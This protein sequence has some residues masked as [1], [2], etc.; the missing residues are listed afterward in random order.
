MD[1]AQAAIKREADTTQSAEL[2][3]SPRGRASRAPPWSYKLG[4]AEETEEV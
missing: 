1:V 3:G 2:S 4:S